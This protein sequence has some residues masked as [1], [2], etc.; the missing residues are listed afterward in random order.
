M[1]LL[2][3]V[4]LVLETQYLLYAVGPCLGFSSST[5]LS[6]D[7]TFPSACSRISNHKYQ[8]YLSSDSVGDFKMMSVNSSHD[9]IICPDQPQIGNAPKSNFSIDKL[10]LRQSLGLNNI[11]FWSFLHGFWLYI[12]QDI[13]ILCIKYIGGNDDAVDLLFSLVGQVWT[14]HTWPISELSLSSAEC[15]QLWHTG[16]KVILHNSVIG[17]ILNVILFRLKF[18]ALWMI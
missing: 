10:G 5:L 16:Q 11:F 9:R 15:L 6:V 18:K 4:H 7:D 2:F 8:T 3:T 1:L 14:W 12:T 17:E 13:F